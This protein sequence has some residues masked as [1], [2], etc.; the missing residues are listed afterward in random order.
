MTAHKEKTVW[1]TMERTTIW[2]RI[3]KGDNLEQASFEK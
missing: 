2:M 1:V 3:H